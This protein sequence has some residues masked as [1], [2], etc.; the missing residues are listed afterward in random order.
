MEKYGTA[1]QPTNDNIIRRMRFACRTTKDTHIH[2]HTHT[3]IYIYKERERETCALSVSVILI[4]HDKC[5]YANAS[6]RYIDTYMASF[7]F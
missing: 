2:T 7:F 5:G 3:H 1:R 4:F 6:R